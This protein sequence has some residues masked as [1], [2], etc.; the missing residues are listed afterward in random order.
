M[1]P[2]GAVRMITAARR[3]F[4]RVVRS[5]YP[6][7]SSRAADTPS[8]EYRLLPTEYFRPEAKGPVMFDPTRLPAW[9]ALTTHH[10]EVAPL[11][12]RDLFRDDPKRFDKFSLRYQD[13]LL[14]FSKN[15]I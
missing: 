1:T 10:A 6:V 11:H 8:P 7:V 9:S 15:R 14:D 12:M 3:P 4:F 13:I 5:R 2:A